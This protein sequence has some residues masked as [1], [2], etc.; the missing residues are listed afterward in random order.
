MSSQ[1]PSDQTLPPP[2]RGVLCL[3]ETLVDLVCERQL[4]ED[5]EL[6]QEDAFVPHFGGAIGNAAVI[7]A[8]AGAQVALAGG[9]GEDRWGRWLRRR[10]EEAG[11]DTEH[12]IL[13]NGAQTPIAL[14]TVDGAGEASYSIYGAG[15]EPILTALGERVRSAVESF[16]ALMIGSNTL[17][18]QP[19]REVTMAAREHALSLGRQLVFDPNLRL[20]RW[21]SAAD[22]QASANA[23]VP[24]ALLVRASLAEAR[25]M[26]GEHDAERAAAALVK[27]GARLVVISLGAEGAMLRGEL[28]ADAAGVRAQVRST[29]GAGDALTGTLLAALE[30]SGF[31]APAVAAALE[32]AVAAGARACERWGAVD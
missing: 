32:D 16:G 10:L 9:A 20:G 28:R 2:P 6:G 12:F 11:V 8:R 17:V 27:A 1:Q 30:R 18:G 3:G 26:T 29:I 14:A 22:A 15:I 23:C 13:L 31:Y 24:G 5:G 7:A 25:L 21:R 4:Q 19:E